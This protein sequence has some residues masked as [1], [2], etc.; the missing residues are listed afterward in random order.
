MSGAALA[1]E[2]GQGETPRLD[3]R[4]PVLLG[5]L[6]LALL[7]LCL[8]GWAATTV[9]GGAVVSQ[10]QIVV[11]GRAKVVQHP[12]GGTIATIA[13]ENGDRVEAG[14]VLL[15]LDPA[16]I[17]LNLE[18][19]RTRISAALAL[20][21]R[22]LAEQAGLET[23]DFSAVAPPEA[24]PGQP[25][26]REAEQAP[27]RTIFEARAETQAGRRE[28]LVET[29][30]RIARQIEGAEAQIEALGAQISLIDPQIAAQQ[31]LLDQGLT[32]SSELIQLRSS[33][34]DLTGQRAALMSRI[35]ELE[36]TQRDAAL[37]VQQAERSRREDVADELSQVTATIEELALE[38]ATRQGEMDR[39]EVRAPVAGVVHEMQVGTLGGVVAP[40]ETLMEIVPQDEGLEIEIRV[41]PASID[42]VHPGQEAEIVLSGL[43]RQTTPKLTGHVRTISASTVPD[44]RTGRAFYRVDLAVAPE[45]LARLDRAVLVPGMPVETYLATGERSVLSY[46]LQP[47]TTHL[48]H[49]F[50]E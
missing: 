31:G 19:A 43:D 12:D 22:L 47:I 9:I 6:A 24:L 4:R 27:Q 28:R 2:R 23:V 39:L 36:T 25:L 50:R 37:E 46:L 18:I 13:V 15:G 38:I 33:R 11:E 41:D 49:A 32:R 26:E 1:Q 5:L 17:A 30:D 34:A 10:G 7:A 42:Q 29:Q 16:L 40:G 48:D 3:L 14:Q 20:K 44:E 45:E 35:A 8:G 21:A